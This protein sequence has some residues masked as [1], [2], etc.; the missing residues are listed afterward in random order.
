MPSRLSEIRNR[1]QQYTEGDGRIDENEWS[2]FTNS[3]SGDIPIGDGR[4]GSVNWQQLVNQIRGLPAAAPTE[5]RSVERFQSLLQQL[6]GDFSELLNLKAKL[7]LGNLTNDEHA[8][9][10]VKQEILQARIHGALQNA[11]PLAQQFNKLSEMKA[12]WFEAGD[13]PLPEGFGES[14]EGGWSS[15]NIAPRAMSAQTAEAARR[16]LG[17]SAR[18]ETVQFPNLR[19]ESVYGPQFSSDAYMKSLSL[20]NAVLQSYD[21]IQANS[22]RGRELVMLFA[23]YAQRA[24]SGDMGAMFQFQKFLTYI[25]SK[26]KAKQQIDLGKKLV[27]LQDDSRRATNKLLNAK[28]D[29][30]DPNAS[31]EQSKLLTEVKAE[32]DA[33]ATSQKLISQSMEEMGVIVETLASLEKSA[34]ESWKRISQT[35]SPR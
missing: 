7:G 26:D 29:P 25:I 16:G 27:A 33:I 18:A 13:Y 4:S 15:I 21:E 32:T 34:L 17:S 9:L 10:L 12:E 5:P 35:Y 2:D 23:Y 3:T 28:F 22:K 14:G 24:A 6:R 8:A 31:F 11:T 1:I 30:N 20:D 19:A